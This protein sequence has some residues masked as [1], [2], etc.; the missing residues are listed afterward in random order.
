MFRT[1]GMATP[2]MTVVSLSADCYTK[3]IA[4]ATMESIISFIFN[5]FRSPKK[6]SWPKLK[7]SILVKSISKNGLAAC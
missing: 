5:M 7:R 2:P 3:G 6:F 4:K 1:S